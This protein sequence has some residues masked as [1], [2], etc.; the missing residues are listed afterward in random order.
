M[1]QVENYPRAAELNVWDFTLSG[2]LQ[3]A[4]RVAD[5][6]GTPGLKTKPEGAEARKHEPELMLDESPPP[7]PEFRPN[8]PELYRRRVIW[9][10]DSLSDP[11][12]KDEALAVPRHLVERVVVVSPPP[13][14]FQV[15]LAFMVPIVEMA[16]NPVHIPEPLYLYEP[17]GTGKGA[18]RAAR[19]VVPDLTSFGKTQGPG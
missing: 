18:G 16:G 12:I 3:F 11:T 15:E 13:D 7:L 10:H 1:Q 2:G 5:G 19:E 8:R 6:P 14:G 4:E 9:L 17:S